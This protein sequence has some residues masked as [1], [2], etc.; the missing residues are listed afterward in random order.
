MFPIYFNE[1]GQTLP[2][3]GTYYVVAGNGIWLHKDT[4][5]VKALL[6]VP[7]ISYLNDIEKKSEFIECNLPKLPAEHV[8]RIKKFFQ[9]V[10]EEHRSESTTSLFF[11]KQTGEYRIYV[12]PQVVSHGAVSYNRE[13]LSHLEEMKDFLCVGTIH[14]H[15]DFGAFHSGTDVDDEEDFDGLHVTFGNNNLDEFSISASIAVN[16]IRQKVDPLQF[17]EGIEKVSEGHYRLIQEMECQLDNWMSQV[18]KPVRTLSEKSDGFSKGD[19]VIWAGEMSSS[20]LR[21]TCGDGPFEVH[22]MSCGNVIIHAPFGLARFD[23]R[24]FKKVDDENKE[25]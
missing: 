16:G 11:N 24:L 17:L 8:F 10:V 22:S 7:T 18:T 1:D 14:S 15:C 4:G 13:G 6:P 5:I 3:N 19:Q 20:D 25:D 12:P 21:A 9:R 2:E 23:Q